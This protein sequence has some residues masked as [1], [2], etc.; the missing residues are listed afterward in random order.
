MKKPMYRVFMLDALHLIIFTF[1][2]GCLFIH[3]FYTDRQ[4]G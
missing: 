1:N 2:S 4:S 3:C